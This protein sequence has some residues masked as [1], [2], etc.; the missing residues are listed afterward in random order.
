MTPDERKAI[1]AQLAATCKEKEGATDADVQVFAAHEHPTTH[2]GKCLTACVMETIGA[3]R[4]LNQ[5]ARN[6]SQ[7]YLKF[8]QK[9]LSS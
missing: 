3:V 7:M 4:I 5:I 9:I 8:L 2:S 6:I 1:A